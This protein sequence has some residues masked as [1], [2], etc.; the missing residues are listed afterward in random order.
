MRKIAEDFW[1]RFSTDYLKTLQKINKWKT[2]HANLEVGDIVL[3]KDPMTTPGIW[4][5]GRIT[6][7]FPD[8]KGVVR[9]VQIK[10]QTKEATLQAAANCVKLLP[11]TCDTEEPALS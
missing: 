10:Q 1:A 7:T 8:K 3:I 11:E 5:M 2:E 6:Q 4:N 9:Q